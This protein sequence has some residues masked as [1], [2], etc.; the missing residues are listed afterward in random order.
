[1]KKILLLI[2]VLICIGFGIWFYY[3]K[4]NEGSSLQIRENPFSLP[5]TPTTSSN[6]VSS[7]SKNNPD[8]IRDFKNQITNSGLI[9]LDNTVISGGYSLQSWHDE[10]KGGEALLKYDQQQGW[11][12]LSMGGGAWSV[13]DLLA[14]GV[15]Y[16]TAKNLVLGLKK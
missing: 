4:N 13:E 3:Y 16:T 14:A 15:P 12:L 7:D 11:V 5:F 8:V 1:M 10:N 9:S 2:L 6:P